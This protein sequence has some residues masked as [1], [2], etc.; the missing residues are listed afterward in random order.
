MKYFILRNRSDIDNLFEKYTSMPL[1][2]D[3]ENELI[4]DERENNHG[5][6]KTFERFYQELDQMLEEFGKSAEE[7]RTTEVAHIPLAVSVPQLLKKV[8]I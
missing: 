7:R 1:D 5:T 8:I 6:S 3:E 2:E 4:F